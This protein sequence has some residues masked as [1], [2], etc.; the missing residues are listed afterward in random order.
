MTLDSAKQLLDDFLRSAVT[1]LE[2]QRVDRSIYVRQMNDAAA[3]LLFPCR[4]DARGPGCFS[5]NVGLRFPSL[6]PIL[7]GEAKPAVPTVMMPLHLLRANKS[8]TEWQFYTSED[9]ESLRDT[10]MSEI[11][12]IGLP[13]IEKYSKLTEL[14]PSLESTTPADWFVLGPEQRLNVL[15]AV[16]F[17]QGEKL[18]ALKTLDEALL[19]RKGALPAK[20]LH[21]VCQHDSILTKGNSLCYGMDG[22]CF[23]NL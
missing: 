8:F 3:L 20:R 23:C 9:L 1:A 21:E 18:A 5:C 13:F 12:G 14:R 16:Q 7:Q 2:F 4:I 17:V 15:A 11:T 6:E 19:E 10:L 22:F